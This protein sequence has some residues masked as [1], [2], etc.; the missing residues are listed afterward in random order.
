VWDGEGATTAF[1]AYS[2]G[3]HRRAYGNARWVATFASAGEAEKAA[4]RIA[5]AAQLTRT[6]T[7]WNGLQP[8]YANPQTPGS[9][10][11]GPLVLWQDGAMLL[12]S[13]IPGE[14]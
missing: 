2:T 9:E 13:T 3:L 10:H 4:P 5:A 1:D 14:G 6:P 7:G 11:R 8:Y 12:M